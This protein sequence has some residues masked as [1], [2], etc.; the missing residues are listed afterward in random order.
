MA[1]GLL[2]LT[3]VAVFYYL[4]AESRY[5]F[6][7]KFPYGF[8]IALQSPDSE[9]RDEVSMDPTASLLA[10]HREGTDEL[11]DAE[12]ATRLPPHEELASMQSL[13]TAT[14]Q[15]SDPAQLR[16]DELFRDC[17][18]APKTAEQG[19]RF[20]LLAFAMPSYTGKTMEL[21]WEPDVAFEPEFAPYEFRLRLLRAPKGISIEP[22][23]IN[24]NQQPRGRITL[25]V[26]KAHSQQEW[27]NGYL[28]ELEARPT[29]TTTVA[30]LQQFFKPDW[31]PTILYARFGM[32]PLLLSTLLITLLAI[33]FATPLGLAAAVYLSEQAS[34]RI[35]E[36]FKPILE[37]LAA[38]PTVVL[39]YFGVVLVA[40]ALQKLFGEALQL[41]SGRGLL[42]TALMMT[43]FILPTV[44][45]LSEDALRAVPNSLREG[46]EALGLTLAECVRLILLPAAKSGLIAAVLLA[47]ARVMGE[48]MIVWILSGGTP[49]MPDFSS[50][51][52]ALATLVK[53]TRAIPD[54]IA[55]EMGNVEFESP[56]YGHLFL[57]GL[58]LFVLTLFI[59]LL[60]FAYRKRA[61]LQF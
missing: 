21:A 5:A 52:A 42:A 30:T 23:E 24:L 46:A 45:S 11:D 38:I 58:T 13:V 37:I 16:A 25:P 41:T 55:I 20:L 59:N 6:T 32:L 8:R 34:P 12:D 57:L 33:T 2:I 44:I 56:H 17:M 48:T 22:I 61:Q 53:P 7:R 14:A 35:R 9:Y 4:L 60:G 50:P 1:G 3:I 43:V 26:W 39:G 47:I 54:T 31:A 28:F 51:S 49:V 36:W 18:R 27:L 19:E 10:T 15:T 29:T 40:P